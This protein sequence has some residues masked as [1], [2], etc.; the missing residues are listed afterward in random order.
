MKTD[1]TVFHIVYDEETQTEEYVTTYFSNVSW[2]GGIGA[3][4]N[5][6]FVEANDLEI[7]IF[8]KDNADLDNQTINIG[9]IVTK[10][11]IVEKIKTKS[12]L[13]EAYNITSIIPHKRGS[14]ATNHIQIGAK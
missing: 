1:I 4:L 6:G 5:K 3:S 14:I 10:G 8:H 2:Q 11:K 7:R 9:D 12:E 13:E